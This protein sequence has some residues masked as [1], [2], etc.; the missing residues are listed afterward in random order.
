L[1]TSRLELKDY[2][3]GILAGDRIV[4]ARTIT[5]VESTRAED[6]RLAGE[7][8]ETVISHTGKSF[9]IGI[10]GAPGAG[11]STFIE[12]FGKTL[13]D[14]GKK[15]AVLTID[16]TSKITRGSILGDKT[17]M[18]ELARHPQAFIRP[19]PSGDTLG[20]VAAFTRESILFCE[21]AGFDTIIVETVGTGQSEITIKN[22]VDFFLLLMQPGSG[23]ELQGIKKGIVEMADGIAITKADGDN[24]KAARATQADFQH[25]LH[26]LQPR[27][28]GWMPEVVTCSALESKGL[29]EILN[30]LETFEKQLSTS[31]HLQ[32]NRQ[33][34]H[35]AWFK[36]HFNFLLS[37]DPKQF[38]KVQ[39]TE[40][41]LIDQ[42]QSHNISPRKAAQ[43]LLLEYHKSIKQKA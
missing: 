29:R 31:G 8:L 24:I 19:T 12:S 30:T 36:D 4:L 1:N 32:S 11:K 40:R 39:D 34:Q 28:S 10:T 26:L 20:G 5:L 27:T 23:D 13:I 43:Q 6:Q 3:N 38:P 22:M 16:P 15:I 33:N 25:A 7:V 41:Q 14:A 21:A 2:K 18:Q 9:R 17:R 37:I 42:I 35:T